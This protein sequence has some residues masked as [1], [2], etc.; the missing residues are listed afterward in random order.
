[1]NLRRYWLK[2]FIFAFF[3]STLGGSLTT[4]ALAYEFL[5]SSD[6]SGTQY[7]WLIGGAAI[8]GILFGP[9]VGRTV[10]HTHHW[11]YW[12]IG[13]D[14]LLAVIVFLFMYIQTPILAA[15]IVFF[16]V[17]LELL[18]GSLVFKVSAV[19]LTSESDLKKF[20][21]NFD[22]INSLGFIFG[23]IAAPI[24]L[25]VFGSIKY[26]FLIDSA[27]Y[28]I[29]AFINLLF[30][31]RIS[32]VN[33]PRIDES[34]KSSERL[35]LIQM[36]KIVRYQ[37]QRKVLIAIL[38]YWTSFSSVA[39]TL[40]LLAKKV[41]SQNLTLYSLPVLAIYF[42][43][44][45]VTRSPGILKRSDL[46]MFKLGTTGAALGMFALIFVNS[47]WSLVIVEFILGGFIGMARIGESTF[48]QRKLPLQI[49][50]NIGVARLLFPMA[51]KLISVPVIVV[52]VNTGGLSSSLAALS[53]GFAFSAYS[54][55]R[56]LSSKSG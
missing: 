9:Y 35:T 13:V 18:Y 26:L 30:L 50:G 33:L 22:N 19:I 47:V 46:G 42:G 39:F 36:W 37:L 8:S 14:A 20:N 40:S 28:L 4:I 21:R 27:S 49:L 51:A 56:K 52:L 12:L 48:L 25:D 5:L 24:L 29:S 41:V 23:P 31:L 34:E 15:S 44:I 1:M 38:I 10:D 6:G 54:S 3:L 32:E 53:L 7:A 16:S 43:R 2:G 17:P 45:L 55:M 11:K